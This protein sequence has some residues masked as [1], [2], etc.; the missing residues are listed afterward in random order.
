MTDLPSSNLLTSAGRWSA[1]RIVATIF[2]NLTD[3]TSNSQRSRSSS[4]FLNAPMNI[5]TKAAVIYADQRENERREN[6]T[7]ERKA[8]RTIQYLEF[9]FT[10][11]SV[12]MPQILAPPGWRTRFHPPVESSPIFMAMLLFVLLV[13]GHT[14][15]RL[16]SSF[17]LD[18]RVTESLQVEHNRTRRQEYIRLS[19]KK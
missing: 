13:S 5:N 9:H 11:R 14:A 15:A 4:I 8:E 17:A 10:S 16:P 7:K 12:F 6:K 1:F 3:F 19:R 2:Y 18:F